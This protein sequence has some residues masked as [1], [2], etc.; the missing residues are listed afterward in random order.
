VVPRAAPPTSQLAS[1]GQLTNVSRP[2]WSVA[3]AGHEIEDAP[4]RPYRTQGT[5]IVRVET[6]DAAFNVHINATTGRTRLARLRVED[7]EDT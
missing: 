2:A 3:D 4:E 5:W 7:V 6:G 1:K